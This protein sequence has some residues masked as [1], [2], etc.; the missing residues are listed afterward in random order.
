MQRKTN[1]YYKGK[2]GRSPLSLAQIETVQLF[3]LNGEA[4]PPPFFIIV[5]LVHFWQLFFSFLLF[6]PPTHSVCFCL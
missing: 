1:E 3:F 5:R 6:H 4:F 2:E